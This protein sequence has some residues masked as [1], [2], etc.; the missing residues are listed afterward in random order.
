MPVGQGTPYLLS[1]LVFVLVRK[2]VCF[3]F[4]KIQLHKFK[5]IGK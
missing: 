5:T 4:I 3:I 1:L 2:H